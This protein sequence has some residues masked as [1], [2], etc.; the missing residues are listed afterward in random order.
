M[1]VISFFV[2]P[3]LLVQQGVY[4]FRSPISLPHKY[5][6]LSPAL[7]KSLMTSTKNVQSVTPSS[8]SS[9]YCSFSQLDASA[10]SVLPS[11]MAGGQLSV[12]L[13]AGFLSA[14]S[15]YL[16]TRQLKR[17]KRPEFHTNAAYTAHSIVAFALM[18]VVSTVG[19]LGWA[20]TPPFSYFDASSRILDPSSAGRWLAAVIVGTFSM[21]DIPTSFM[22]KELRKPDVIIHHIVMLITA[23]IGSTVLPMHYLLYY[24]GVSELS[25]IPLVVYDQVQQ[26]LKW[27]VFSKSTTEKL[28]EKVEPILGVLTAI[29]FTLVRAISFP[30]VTLF[31]FVP[32]CITVLAAPSS[33][34]VGFAVTGQ[35]RSMLKFSVGASLAFTALQLYW[36]SG[37]VKTILSGDSK[38]SGDEKAAV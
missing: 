20:F 12:A 6:S 22:V 29:C 36:F 15:Q 2:F 21:W 14:G 27:N 7:P 34:G 19:V 1:I 30:K 37:L 9:S 16:L 26:W 11:C 32:D 13:S 24:F 5:A 18:L 25:S 23:A 4:S 17:S 33:D 38:E 31:S 3:L 28:K 10:S 35:I 8:S